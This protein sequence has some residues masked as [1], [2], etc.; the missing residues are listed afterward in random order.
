M[1]RWIVRDYEE[2]VDGG[3][4]IANLTEWTTVAT[5]Q[6]KNGEQFITLPNHLAKAIEHASTKRAADLCRALVR[7]VLFRDPLP[8]AFHADIHRYLVD[9]DAINNS[10]ESKMFQWILCG[11]YKNMS[12]ATL[13]DPIALFKAKPNEKR[14]FGLG[15]KFFDMEQRQKRRA[16][17]P[18]RTLSQSHWE[19][20]LKHPRA[21]FVQIWTLFMRDPSGKR[22]TMFQEKRSDASIRLTTE[23]SKQADKFMSFYG[24]TAD[25]GDPTGFQT[26]PDTEGVPLSFTDSD[27][28][29]AILGYEWAKAVH[30]AEV[31]ERKEKKDQTES[32]VD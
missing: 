6:K 3:T 12:K 22:P 26:H 19:R 28:Y 25:L 1:G 14:A 5:H 16:N 18:T 20:F 7:F 30:W 9:K 2:G 17:A 15:Y 8:I 13:P 24:I 29:F 32:L 4:I 27:R 23:V 21:T 10:F 11:D 31:A